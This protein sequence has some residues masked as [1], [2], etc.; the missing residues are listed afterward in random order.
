MLGVGVIQVRLATFLSTFWMFSMPRMTASLSKSSCRY[1]AT[2][3][4]VFSCLVMTMRPRETDPVPRY[5]VIIIE[6]T[7]LAQSPHSY[8][9]VYSYCWSSP[10]HETTIA[11]DGDHHQIREGIPRTR[12][13]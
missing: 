1:G 13:S 3:T 11:G 12:S 8:M 4:K 7:E 9:G 6:A 10:R 5:W 2:E